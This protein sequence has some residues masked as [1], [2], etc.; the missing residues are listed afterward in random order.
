MILPSTTTTT[1]HPS[2]SMDMESKTLASLPSEVLLRILLL[3]P[4]PAL[5]AISKTSTFFHTLFT[6][7]SLLQYTHAL[8]EEHLLDNL[9]NQLVSSADKLK[10]L[11]ERSAAWR[12]HKW[13]KRQAFVV[14]GGDSGTLY[15]FLGGVLGIVSRAGL[16]LA[17]RLSSL[18]AERLSPGPRGTGSYDA[19]L[20]RAL[21]PRLFAL[22][23]VTLPDRAPSPSLF[24]FVNL[25]ARF[26]QLWAYVLTHPLSLF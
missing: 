9:S 26:L 20:V 2:G 15:D 16:P 24:L 14:E 5:V 13:A 7:S 23:V 4:A 25:A 1:Q 3:L 19:V 6:Q 10:F 22:R 17:I 18:T 11:R 8:Q 21:L 12:S